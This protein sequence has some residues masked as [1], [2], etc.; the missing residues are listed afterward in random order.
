MGMPVKQHNRLCLILSALLFALPAAAPAAAQT[1]N[2]GTIVV[3]VVA[4]QGLVV[5]DARVSVTNAATGAVSD[6]VSGDEGSV[7][8][9]AL[10]LTGTYTVSVTKTGFT[11]EDVT[12]LTL[13]AGES[14]RVKVKL[15]ASGGKSEVTVYGT[16]DGVHSD[17]QIGRSLTTDQIKRPLHRF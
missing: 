8:M 3:T 16:S 14:A 9:A 13:R 12:G 5:K 2:T 1:P 11:A 17:P 7:T 6:V 10:S 15:V 4:Q